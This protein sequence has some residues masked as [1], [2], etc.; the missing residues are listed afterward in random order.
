L[1]NQ[2]ERAETL[3]NLIDNL[4]LS[5]SHVREPAVSGKLSPRGAVAL[6]RDL[7]K[8]HDSAFDELTISELAQ[9][10]CAATAEGHYIWAHRREIMELGDK[11]TPCDLQ[12]VRQ[13]KRSLSQASTDSSSTSPRKSRESAALRLRLSIAAI[14]GLTAWDWRKVYCKW[15]LVHPNAEAPLASGSTPV[16]GDYEAPPSWEALEFAITRVE[17]IEML[18]QCR[19]HVRIKR[20]SRCLGIVK[21]V[22]DR[23]GEV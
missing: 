21:C 12:D 6:L 22:F 7:L 19:L 2:V 11:L 4:D 15:Q 20:P 8:L 3:H 10:Q 23:D 16:H 13:M 9:L 1:T 18:R 14:D 5:T 17:S